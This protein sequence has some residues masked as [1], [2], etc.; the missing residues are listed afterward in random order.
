MARLAWGLQQFPAGGG[1]VC[2][3]PLMPV[4]NATALEQAESIIGILL[5]ESITNI[6]L[7]KAYRVASQ[8]ALKLRNGDL[9]FTYARKEAEI[10][11]ICLGT[12]LDDLRKAGAASECWIKAIRTAMEEQ[13]MAR[14]GGNPDA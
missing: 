4:D 12:E 6:E 1:A 13:A 3:H 11:K 10:E 2:S 5:K 9:A 8:Q 14:S 7:T